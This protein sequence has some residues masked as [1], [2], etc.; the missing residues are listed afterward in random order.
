[1]KNFENKFVDGW[2]IG[3]GILLSFWL[4]LGIYAK[5]EKLGWF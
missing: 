3:T 2:L 4:I 1:M 5:M